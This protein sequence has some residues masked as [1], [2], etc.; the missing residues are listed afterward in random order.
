MK[1]SI[2]QFTTVIAIGLTAFTLTT[3]LAAQASEQTLKNLNTAF[4]G[5]SNAAN[6]YAAF[7]KKADG[8]GYP[9]VAK[10]FRAASAAEAIHRD[11]H[12]AAILELGGVPAT[13]QL[14][15][16]SPGSTEENLKAAIKGESYERDTMY[17]EFLALAKADDARAAIRTLEFAVAAEKEH[18][19]LYSEAL[20]TLGKN[21]PANYYVCRVC[22]MTL[23]E[24]PL[25]KC[26]S[27][28]K[29]KDEYQQII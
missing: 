7:A 12:K 17:P 25:K 4:E 19:L 10:L 22:G 27:C 24:M 26:P 14:E 2:L 13:F 8:D 29:S 1:H 21:A 23:T 9:Q 16:V 3:T 28:R 18:A 5:E 6:R 20:A 15:K 11:T